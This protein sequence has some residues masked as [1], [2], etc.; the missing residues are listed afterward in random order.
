MKQSLIKKIKDEKIPNVLITF[1]ETPSLFY[2]ICDICVIPTEAEGHSNVLLASMSHAN[3]VIASHIPGISDVIKDGHN[4]FL[5]ENNAESLGDRIL[6]I[7]D[8][9]EEYSHIGEN[10]RKT[11][12]SSYDIKNIS[13]KYIDFINN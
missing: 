3:I 12:Q 6:S 4:G 9:Y 11:V 8:H 5:I 7:K 10:A 13:Q 1:S 2:Q